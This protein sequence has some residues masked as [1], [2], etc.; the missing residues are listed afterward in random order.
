MNFGT[1]LWRYI[2]YSM[3]SK[4]AI[5]LHLFSVRIMEN[6][7]ESGKMS[8][9]GKGLIVKVHIQS[10]GYRVGIKVSFLQTTFAQVD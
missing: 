4:K 3:G 2:S 5:E 8:S 6:K 7:L 9:R 1:G 10:K